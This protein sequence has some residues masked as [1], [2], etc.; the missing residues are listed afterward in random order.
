MLVLSLPANLTFTQVG[1]TCILASYAVAAFPF[2][3]MPIETY[4]QDYCNH[5]G[6]RSANP[7]LSCEQHFDAQWRQRSISG[8]QLLQDIHTS[9]KGTVF[10]KCSRAFSLRL[11]NDVADSMSQIEIELQQPLKNGLLVF[12]PAR[13]HSIMVACDTRGLYSYDTAGGKRAKLGS[14]LEVGTTG[15]GLV[16]S[17]HTSVQSKAQNSGLA[18]FTASHC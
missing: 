7:A 10:E 15:D 18:A 1:Q 2:T 17:E 3:G 6:I 5:Y 16:F 9:S 4:Y 8:Y 12:L 13:H 11:V 14:I